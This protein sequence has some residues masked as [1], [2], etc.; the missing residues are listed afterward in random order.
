MKLWESPTNQD[1]MITDAYPYTVKEEAG[2]LVFKGR[3][4]EKSVDEESDAKITVVDIVENF[5]LQPYGGFKKAAFA[6]WAKAFMPKR[7][8]QLQ[9]SNPTKVDEFMANAKKYVSYIATH[10]D[11]FEFYM[12]ASGDPDDY[13]M[14]MATENDEP[15]FYFLELACDASKC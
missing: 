14:A 4:I 10:F 2:A 12:G 7:R 3:Y 13:L 8:T 5:N 11:D 1:E 9:S 15:V 6:G